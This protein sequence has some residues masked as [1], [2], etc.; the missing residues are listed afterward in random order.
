MHQRLAR[1]LSLAKRTAGEVVIPT[2]DLITVTLTTTTGELESLTGA[3]G[4]SR[5]PVLA[6]G[7]SADIVGFVHVKDILTADPD[8]S[9]PWAAQ[10][11]HPMPRIQSDTTVPDLLTQMRRA[12]S[13]MGLVTRGADV[14]GVVALEDAVAELVGG[15]SD[16]AHVQH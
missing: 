8:P 4:F 11:L 2:A 7:R 5:F 10:H 12:R 15:I 16:A 3:T 6:S 1:A 14:L 9:Q 13:H